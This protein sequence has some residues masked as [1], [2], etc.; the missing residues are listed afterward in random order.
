MASACKQKI[1]TIVPIFLLCQF[2]NSIRS[3]TIA[4]RILD[5][6]QTRKKRA[7][8][9]PAVYP[10]AKFLLYD[11]GY[12]TPGFAVVPACSLN[13]LRGVNVDVRSEILPPSLLSPLRNT[14]I[15]CP[16]GTSAINR[17]VVFRR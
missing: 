9:W 4:K 12:P 6:L 15:G 13:R 11:L 17:G 1:D 10:K 8:R 14:H 2:S 5:G 16:A 7:E 3:Y